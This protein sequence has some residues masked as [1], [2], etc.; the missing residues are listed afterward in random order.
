MRIVEYLNEWL[1]TRSG[2]IERSTYEQETIYVTKHLVP[3]FSAE[4]KELADLK[5]MDI[6]KYINYK[7][8]SGRLDGKSG[9]LSAPSVRKHM[10]I[11]KMALND[12]VLFGHIPSNP[13][14]NT[15]LKKQKGNT[16]KRVVL[17]TAEQGRAVLD[18]LKDSRYYLPVFLALYFGLRRSEVLGLKWSAIDLDKG[19]LTINHVV[20]KET[21]IMERDGAKSASS[22]RSFELT[23]EMICLLRREKSRRGVL[24]DYVC[25]VLMES[26][27]AL[28]ALHAAFNDS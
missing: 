7:T 27:F 9:G 4:N 12:A 5:P 10:S 22:I 28:T 19:V 3:F 23:D 26:L 11:L 20:V 14:L 25:T 16:V 17:M 2:M 18:A 8:V 15:K 6:Q 1:G 21:T 24:S 13:A